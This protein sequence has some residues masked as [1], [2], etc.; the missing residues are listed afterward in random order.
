MKPKA[1]LKKL[2]LCFGVAM[3]LMEPSF[4][5]AQAVPGASKTQ[6]YSSLFAEE[7]LQ[8]T[9]E[10]DGYREGTLRAAIIAANGIRAND[11]FS[12]VKIVFA[13]QVHRIQLNHGPLPAIEGSLTTL[14]CFNS[15]GKALIELPATPQERE[16]TEEV[17]SDSDPYSEN[18]NEEDSEPQHVLSIRSNNNTIRGCHFTGAPQAGLA[19]YGNDNTVEHSIFGYLKEQN[20]EEL[21]SALLRGTPQGNQGPGLLLGVGAHDNQIHHND[22]IGNNG[23]GILVSSQAGGGNHLFYNYFRK[24]KGEPIETQPG[25]WQTQTPSLER[26]T[27][28]GEQYQLSGTCAPGSQIQIY[29]M[30]PENAE[31]GQLVAETKA[32]EQARSTQ[33]QLSFPQNAVTSPALV[34]LAHSPNHNSSALSQAFYLSGNTA[35][36]PNSTPSENIF[37][38]PSPNTQNTLPRDKTKEKAKETV[39]NLFPGK[40][41]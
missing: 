11:A 29:E 27:P 13:P 20:S 32:F 41:P 26:I 35:T 25:T 40:G 36:S 19:I 21:G 16:E 15:Q 2:F 37:S 5:S 24:N 12:T 8:V 33:F 30:D 39:I 3:T 38:Q 6:T 14:E 18:F 1:H 4:A 28:S 9:T 31:V 34:A 10:R 7:I 17:E 22:F 23:A